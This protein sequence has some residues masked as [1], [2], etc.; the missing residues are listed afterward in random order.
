M[1]D[2][3]DTLYELLPVVHRRRDAEQ[4]FPLKA[5]LHVISEQV[6]IVDADIE[7]L[8]DNWFI[9][10]CD[11]WVVPYLAQLIG[12]RPAREAGPPASDSPTARRLARVLVPRRE[13]ANTLRH[14]RRRGTLALLE[15]LAHDVAG[16]P[17]RAVEFY[18]L[19]GWT[20]PLN[21]RRMHRGRMADLRDGDALDLVNGPFDPL[22]HTVDVRRIDARRSRGRHNIPSVGVFVWRL[23]AYPVTRAPAYCR[24]TAGA[25]CYAFSVL[26]N[27]APLFT[28]PAPE[29]SP[30]HIAGPLHVP[31][32]IRRRALERS[33]SDH[34]G[35]S[36]SLTI[37]V[38][39]WGSHTPEEPVPPEAI[40]VADLTDWHYRPP[41][42]HV[43]VDPVLGRLVFP[44]R[45]LPR[46]G[47]W[48]SYHYG[49]SD[50]MGGGEYLRPISHPTDA[51]VYRVGGGAEH[52]RLN[53]AIVRWRD[54]QPEHAVIEI[55]DSGVY[56]EQVNLELAAG[57]S[58][59]LRAAQGRRPVIRLMD[60][61]TARPDALWVHG[62]EGSRFTLDGMLVAGRGVHFQGALAAVTIRHAT[63]VP[64]WTLEPDCEPG[65]PTEPSLELTDTHTCVT[66]EKTILGS[67]QVSLDEVGTDPV[68][69]HVT[70]SILD[71]TSPEREAVGAP[72]WPLAHAV[73][74]IQR[75]T[76]F[77]EVHAHAIELAEDS[78]FHGRIHVARR[79][80]GCMRFCY[81][82]PG[83]RTPRRFMCQPDLAEQAERALPSDPPQPPLSERI[84]LARR[85]VRPLF[86]S[87]RYGT[88]TYAQLSAH[89]PDEI[90]R[91]AEH[92][93]E[94]GAFHDLFQPQRSDNLELR[95]D[96]SV[97]AGM[98]VAVIYAS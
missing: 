48:V 53:D 16:W 66:V 10:T 41:R 1:S 28:D 75:T 82:T 61:Q 29:P 90:A 17:A 27:D 45:Q 59:Q 79:Q 91:G 21:H 83:S 68:S 67:I 43:A 97:P 14:R 25:H 38:D 76:V 55:V 70:D 74:T 63:L 9:E 42:D 56:V 36:R 8:Y 71:A 88:P 6:D 58:F 95:L 40:V 50:A 19:L 22:A 78:I 93:S 44:P 52:E 62:G 60:W 85:R 51:V 34:Y 94:M 3:R 86:N 26:G 81:V 69:I 96:E 77:G 46:R 89:C 65:R 84:D 5:L 31:A 30:H 12:F 11:D 92:E 13:V 4:G 87:M 2:R 54:E 24:E 64:G 72:S 98:D 23:G 47:V 49:F 32:P 15:L 73:L 57:Q 18:R 37:W 39:G 35:P 20:Q 7:R 80:L 33:I